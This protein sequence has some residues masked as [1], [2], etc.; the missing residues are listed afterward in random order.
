MKVNKLEAE[1]IFKPASPEEIKQAYFSLI[2]EHSPEKKPESFKKIRAAY[3]QVRT[4]KKREETDFLLFAEG[5]VVSDFQEPSGQ[6]INVRD[7]LFDLEIW[8]I[9]SNQ[10]DNENG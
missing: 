3:E 1:T 8:N 2:K 5:D 6:M 7:D 4:S 10:A 9:I